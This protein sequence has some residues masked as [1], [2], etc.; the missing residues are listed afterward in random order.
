[1][2]SKIPKAV[3]TLENIDNATSEWVLLWAQRVESQRAQKEALDSMNDAKDFDS[4][5]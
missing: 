5:I 4:I 3:S 2:I 1:M